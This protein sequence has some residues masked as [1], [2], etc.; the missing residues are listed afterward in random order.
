MDA[1][2]QV[3]I[4]PAVQSLFAWDELD[5]C[6]RSQAEHSLRQGM[7]WM[8][9]EQL[10]AQIK[11]LRNWLLGL[12]DAFPGRCLVQRPAPARPGLPSPPRPVLLDP[13]LGR[14]ELVRRRYALDAQQL[15]QRIWTETYGALVL[16]W[17][18]GPAR[19]FGFLQ[20]AYDRGRPVA[21]M[22][23]STT[24]Q[25]SAVKLPSDALRFS[26]GGVFVL[27]NSWRAGDLR[28][29]MRRVAV[30]VTRIARRRPSSWMPRP[31]ARPC[32]TARPRIR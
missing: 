19:W 13:L 2:W 12:I 10:D 6:L 16:A 32:A 25:P 15:N 1:R 24:A 3:P 21:F 26:P 29:I 5:I 30:E 4:A 7:D 23:P 9:R 31:S 14:L 8:G 11:I 18:T 22:R 27:R 17:L 28:Q 20:I